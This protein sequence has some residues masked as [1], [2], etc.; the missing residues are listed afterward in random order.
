M[1]QITTL[2]IGPA[3]VAM[4]GHAQLPRRRSLRAVD[5]PGRGHLTVVISI[6]VDDETP[7]RPG[8]TAA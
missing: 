5:R 1:A 8:P 7:E 4:R 2:P 6:V 3:R